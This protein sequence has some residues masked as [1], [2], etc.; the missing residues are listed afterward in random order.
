MSFKIDQ[1]DRRLINTGDVTDAKKSGA[2]V[3]KK[4]GSVLSNP[5][6]A[7]LGSYWQRI[8]IGSAIHE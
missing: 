4:G 1:R 3:D 2:N 7:I 8:T 6:Q 5:Q